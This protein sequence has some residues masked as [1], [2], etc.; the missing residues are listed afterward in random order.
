MLTGI[1]KFNKEF[2]ATPEHQSQIN[3]SLLNDGT[4]I[5]KK[6]FDWQPKQVVKFTEIMDKKFDLLNF[7]GFA[8]PVMQQSIANFATELNASI[9]DVSVFIF[10][11]NKLIYLAV[12]NKETFVKHLS[13]EQHFKNLGIL[14]E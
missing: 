4:V 10:E 12:Y 11:Q 8:K 7:E 14:D 13:L 9:E 3:V 2:N 6:C 5:Y 1:N